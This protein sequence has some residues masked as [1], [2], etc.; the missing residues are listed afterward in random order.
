MYE[1]AAFFLFGTAYGLTIGHLI[2]KQHYENKHREEIRDLMFRFYA[3]E[4]AS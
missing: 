4:E 1:L 2:T 3:R